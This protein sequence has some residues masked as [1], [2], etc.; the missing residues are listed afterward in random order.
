M[1]LLTSKLV[2]IPLGVV[3][4]VVFLV[5]A[6]SSGDDEGGAA[7]RPEIGP[8]S[9]KDLRAGDCITDATSTKGDVTTFDLVPCARSHDG[10][11]YTLIELEGAAYP[12]VK[13]VSGK[14]QRG[15]RA[16]LRR[17]LSE[18]EFADPGL[19]YKFVY[20]TAASWGQGDRE[21]T[22][23]ATFKSVRTVPLEQRT[24]R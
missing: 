6:V 4:V 12:G 5:I 24:A 10:E 23:V 9:A 1:K 3:A 2:L 19:G 13:F 14:G 8:I 18:K 15:C 21:I 22:C 11:V 16:R 20:P 17:Q 7:K